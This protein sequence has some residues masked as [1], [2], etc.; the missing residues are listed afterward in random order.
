[1]S[2]FRHTNVA[3]RLD[4]SCFRLAG[5]RGEKTT[6]WCFVV[7]SCLKMRQTQISYHIYTE[8]YQH[9]LNLLGRC[10]YI[11][12]FQQELQEDVFNSPIITAAEAA[13]GLTDDEKANAKV[14]DVAAGTGMCAVQ[15]K[16]S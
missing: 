4:I 11:L 7:F 6:N 9:M 8:I 3:W 12:I 10:N 2:C 14:F 1:M 5:R 15:V 16:K 13:E